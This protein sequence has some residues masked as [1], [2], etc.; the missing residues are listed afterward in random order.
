MADV[1]SKDKRS[2]IMS[3]VRGKDTSPEIIVRSLVHRLGYRF[4]LYRKDLPGKPDLTFPSRRKVIFVHG[5]FWHGHDCLRGDRKPKSNV[6]YWRN[7]IRRNNQ[8]DE[9]NQQRLKE[10]GWDFLVIWECQI[11]DQEKLKTILVGFLEAP[12]SN[13]SN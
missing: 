2:W 7:K 3:R 13:P 12:P 9:V 4:R 5:C 10:L 6:V 8:R 11:K 1:F